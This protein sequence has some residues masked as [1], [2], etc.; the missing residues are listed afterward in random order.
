MHYDSHTQ[1][2]T[3]MREGERGERESVCE[4][5]S[6]RRGEERRERERVRGEKREGWG[7]L[8]S[9][10]KNYEC[11]ATKKRLPFNEWT[12]LNQFC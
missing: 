1:D 3:A 12:K 6:E 8:K 9:N 10:D 4:R 5:E 11:L 7:S 2:G